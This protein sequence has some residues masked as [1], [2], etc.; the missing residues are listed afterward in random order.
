MRSPTR[1]CKSAAAQLIQGDFVVRQRRVPTRPS[2]A[3][4]GSGVDGGDQRIGDDS[5]GVLVACTFSINVAR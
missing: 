2:G 4:R 3:E 1:A 5:A